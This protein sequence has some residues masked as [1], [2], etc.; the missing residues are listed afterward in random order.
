[1][2]GAGKSKLAICI[3]HGVVQEVVSDNECLEGASV[4]I[5]EDRKPG[6]VVKVVSGSLDDT[7]REARARTV[8]EGLGIAADIASE[9][10][11]ALSKRR[12]DDPRQVVND[13]ADIVDELAEICKRAMA[14][15]P[16]N[17]STSA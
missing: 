11:L 9:R 15:L 13:L 16:L 1:M 3:E 5:V 2:G 6:R 14:T 8:C 10:M 17:A 12:Y 7:M 4:A